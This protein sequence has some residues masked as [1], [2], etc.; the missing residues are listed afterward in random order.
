MSYSNWPSKDS[1]GNDVKTQAVIFGLGSM[2]NHSRTEQNVVWERDLT[3]QF[4]T[5]RAL[6]DIKAGEELCKN[7]LRQ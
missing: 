6:R 3:H 4:I 7:Q 1:S 5:Y 2:F